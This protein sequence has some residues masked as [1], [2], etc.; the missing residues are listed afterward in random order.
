MQEQKVTGSS[1][2][3][4]FGST[5]GRLIISLVVPLAALFVL[6][7]GFLF[8]RDST[9]PQYVITLVAIAWGVGGVAL[10]FYVA[11][12][13]VE[14]LPR[15]WMTRLQPF[16]FIGPAVLLLGWYLAIPTI[17]TLSL[18][19]FN[20]D[21]SQFVGLDNYIAVFTQRNMQEALRNNLLWMFFGTAFTVSAGLFIA[22]LADRSRFERV[23]KSLI[24][25]PMAISMVGAGVIWKF[26]YDFNPNIGLLNAGVTTLGGQPQ[27]W[28]SQVQPWNNLFLIIVM[29]WLQTGYAMVL[30]SAAIKGIPDEL[31]E[32]ARVDGATEVQAFFRI[33]IPNIAGTLLT[34][35]TTVVIFT[36]KIFDIV[37]VMTGGQYG[38]DVIGVRFYREMFSNRNQGYGAAIA[39]VL[40]IAVVPVMIY[41]LRQFGKRDVF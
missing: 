26:V 10:L 20:A 6:Y 25:L 13:V 19:F 8:L 18:S 27:A 39:I 4:F 15:D 33:I 9:A 2:A 37:I 3:D 1:G 31:L 21:G 41:N 29:V 12:W 11:N 36:L 35:I 23:A 30:L 14:R 40:L 7:A 5:A 24:F 38:T 34:V 32:A 22:I 16:V 17:R 28:L